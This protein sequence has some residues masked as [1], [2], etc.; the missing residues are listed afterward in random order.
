MFDK[1]LHADFYST[2]MLNHS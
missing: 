2:E 1:P